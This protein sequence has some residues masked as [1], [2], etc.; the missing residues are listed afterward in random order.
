MSAWSGVVALSGFLYHGAEQ[1]VK[2]TP[3]MPGAKVK[4][5]WSTGTGWG[6]YERAR[7]EKGVKV[8][9]QV[10]H[11]SLPC[12][13]CAVEGAGASKASLDA[14]PL[15]HET[16][17]EGALSVL[18]FAEPVTVPEGGRLSIELA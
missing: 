2:L 12:R 10:L 9:I 16:R 13:S 17:R 15:K 6:V 1:S 7:E 8:S 4:C 11:G 18:C 3:R 14:K 5:F